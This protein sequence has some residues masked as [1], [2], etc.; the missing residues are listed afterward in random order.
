MNSNY[1]DFLSLGSSLQ[2]GEEKVEEVRVGLLG[3]KRDVEGL[4]EKVDDR[5]KEVDQL[6]EEKRRVRK[7][8]QRG[9]GLLEVD[10]RLEELEEGLLLKLKG[11][12]TRRETDTDDIE[13]SES[14]EDSGNEAAK[15]ST[16]ISRLQRRVIQFVYTRKLADKIGSDQPFIAKQE[17]RLSRVRNTLLLDIGSAFKQISTNEHA[18]GTTLKILNIYRELGE[19]DEALRILK[20]RKI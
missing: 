9:R 10:Q 1:Q 15:N 2:G 6:V 7:E 18:R 11:A 14:E 13:I 17:E 19:P 8:I 16:S 4:K 3:F 20:D 12:T 5:R